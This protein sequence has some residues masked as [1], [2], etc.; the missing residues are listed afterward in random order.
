MTE[1]SESQKTNSPVDAAAQSFEDGAQAEPEPAQEEQPAF[2]T[3]PFPRIIELF[4]AERALAI[5]QNM[6]AGYQDDVEETQLGK[7]KTKLE[8]ENILESNRSLR[9][10]Y[11]NDKRFKSKVRKIHT[12]L[13]Q[14]D[15]TRHIT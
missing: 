8:I 5:L 9:E 10:E 12:R 15:A 11:Y 4:A 13:L 6:P 1:Q 3:I 7:I 2:V 14:P